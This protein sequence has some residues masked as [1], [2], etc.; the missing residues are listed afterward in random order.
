VDLGIERREP[1]SERTR[2]IELTTSAERFEADFSTDFGRG[3]LA[4]S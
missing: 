3:I 2:T 4:V 1:E